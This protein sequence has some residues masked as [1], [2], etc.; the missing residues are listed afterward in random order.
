MLQHGSVVRVNILKFKSHA[1]LGRINHAPRAQE[2][3]SPGSNVD[4]YCGSLGKWTI[5]PS[6]FPS[7]PSS[8]STQFLRERNEPMNPAERQLAPPTILV[9]WLGSTCESPSRN[10]TH[11]II[12]SDAT[13]NGIRTSRIRVVRTP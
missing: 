2:N 13:S 4:L 7:R 8:I 1:W 6:V 9:V 11:P 3:G 5:H 10:N 12:T